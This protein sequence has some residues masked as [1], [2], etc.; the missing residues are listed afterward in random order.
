M[1]F[2][3]S[4]F[5]TFFV[6]PKKTVIFSLSQC[7]FR[8]TRGTKDIYL[9]CW[10]A[11]KQIQRW[12]KYHR[13]VKGNVLSM[14]IQSRAN[15]WGSYYPGK[16]VKNVHSNQYR[17]KVTQYSVPVIKGQHYLLDQLYL[18]VWIFEFIFAWTYRICQVTILFV[19]MF[20]FIFVCA[21]QKSALFVWS[22]SAQKVDGG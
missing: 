4:Y 10:L 3:R 8:K 13:T 22:S 9:Q 1:L 5:L 21:N 11:P 20:E 18:Y 7:L 16:S 6:W 12:S 19:W 2:S 17:K 15:T 14:I